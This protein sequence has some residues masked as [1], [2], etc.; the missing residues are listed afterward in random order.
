[1][2]ETPEFRAACTLYHKKENQM[3]LNEVD[4]DVGKVR[5]S[6]RSDGPITEEPALPADI[7]ESVDSRRDTIFVEE[8]LISS[9]VGR[10]L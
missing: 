5:I 4:M 10:N 3:G 6:R 2:L 8:K 1:M 9:C 7:T